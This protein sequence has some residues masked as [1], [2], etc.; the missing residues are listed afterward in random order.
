MLKWLCESLSKSQPFSFGL[1][2]MFVVAHFGHHVIGALL[3]PMMP[4]IRSDLKLDYTEAGMVISAFSITAGISQLPA[5]WLADRLSARLMILVGVSGVAVAGLLAGFS[6]SY[7]T[8]IASLVVAALFGGGYHPAASAAI[9][10]FVP[11]EKRG[12]S[13]GLHLIGGSSSNWVVPLIASPIA[14]I[15]GWRG[16]YITFAIPVFFLG[17]MLYRIIGRRTNIANRTSQ[18]IAKSTVSEVIRI[19]WQIMAPFLFLSI[20]T[21]TLTQSIAAYYSLYLV[22]HFSLS[23]PT[24]ALFMAIQPGIVILTA[25]LAGYLA[26]RFGSILLMASAS[27]LLGP[28]LLAM[29]IVPNVAWFVALLVLM[30]VV[31]TIRSPSSESFINTNVPSHRRSTILGI[32]FFAGSEMSALLTPFMGYLMDTRGFGAAFTIAGTTSTLVALICIFLIWS[33][34]RRLKAS[35]NS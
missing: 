29:R 13:L 21:G 22:D 5:G 3:N 32:Y 20:T 24:A 2:S 33:T 4:F 31:I 28:V 7:L 19:R 27:L 1:L 12:R 25:P 17:I 30:G 16:S 10:T 34:N 6:N 18:P 11:I 23:A 9:A 14:V 15:W 26:D 35:E 8:L